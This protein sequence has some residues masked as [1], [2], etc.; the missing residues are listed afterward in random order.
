MVAWRDTSL[1][2]TRWALSPWALQL[3]LG[4]HPRADPSLLYSQTQLALER[5]TRI[6]HDLCGGLGARR[7]GQGHTAAFL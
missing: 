3:R 7:P 2:L 6:A 1:L 4:R 5:F